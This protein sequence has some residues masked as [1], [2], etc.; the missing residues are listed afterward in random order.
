MCQEY[1][2]S[3]GNSQEQVSIQLI[4]SHNQQ[5]HQGRYNLPS[6]SEIAAV[7]SDNALASNFTRDVIVYSRYDPTKSL[8]INKVFHLPSGNST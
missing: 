4:I 5:G 1:E 2:L 8:R 3:A 6:S 7:F